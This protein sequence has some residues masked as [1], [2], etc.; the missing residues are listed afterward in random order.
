MSNTLRAIIA[1]LGIATST[2]AYAPPPASQV[3]PWP[4][5]F[6]S[7]QQG[8]KNTF[9]G[10][11]TWYDATKNNAWYTRENKWGESIELYAAAGPA[12]RKRMGHSYMAKPYP[13]DITSSYSGKTVR[14]WVT[15]FCACG[16]KAKDPNDTRLIDLS[17]AVWDA[18]GVPLG[19]GVT[20]VTIEVVD[21]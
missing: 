20:R 15:D 19:L 13:L 7:A 3:A 5:D 8:K 6:N 9:N 2:P 12:L 11:A 18:L 10:I 16:G 21:K 17:P 1:T 4:R 14:V